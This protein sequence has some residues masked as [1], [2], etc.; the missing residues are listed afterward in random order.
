MVAVSYVR[1]TPD[2][3]VARFRSALAVRRVDAHSGRTVPAEDRCF[4]ET[5]PR[6]DA[7]SS[8][9]RPCSCPHILHPA[10]YTLPGQTH[11][12]FHVDLC[13][14][15]WRNAPPL[16]PLTPQYWGEPGGAQAPT[17]PSIGGQGGRKGRQ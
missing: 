3:S 13:R 11:L 16:A 17:P 12:N 14:L 8:A 7:S 10:L 4:I 15:I 6:L 9:A 5:T 2:P 1:D